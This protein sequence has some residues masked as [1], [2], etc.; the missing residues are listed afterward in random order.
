MGGGGYLS[1]LGPLSASLITN[2]ISLNSQSKSWFHF[3]RLTTRLKEVQEVQRADPHCSAAE[4]PVGWTNK[5]TALCQ[6]C[7]Q[8]MFT[9][10][11]FT[12][13]LSWDPWIRV[14]LLLEWKVSSPSAR[15]PWFALWTNQWFFL[16]LRNQQKNRSWSC[17]LL[18][19]LGGGKAVG[20]PADPLASVSASLG[21]SKFVGKLSA[22]SQ[23]NK[24]CM[25]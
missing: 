6:G 9:C 4:W 24:V 2:H 15:C 25:Q 7:S 8:G 22:I 1:D 11:F 10:L 21:T 20:T 18:F 17:L 3:E 12:M 14:A 23:R 5:T 16:S 13:P 19:S